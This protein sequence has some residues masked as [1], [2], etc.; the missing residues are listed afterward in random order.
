MLDGRG[1]SDRS[2]RQPAM[3]GA[4]EGGRSFERGAELDDEIPF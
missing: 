3:A 2:E 4:S 1:D